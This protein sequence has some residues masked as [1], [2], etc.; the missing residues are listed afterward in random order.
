MAKPM[1]TKDKIREWISD[2]LR[3]MM[4]IGG[5][6][7]VVGL[8]ALAIHLITGRSDETKDSQTSFPVSQS[9]EQQKSSSSDLSSEENQDPDTDE[10]QQ[11]NTVSESTGEEAGTLIFGANNQQDVS[12]LMTGYFTALASGDVEELRRLSDQL[13]SEEEEQI[14]VKA[15]AVSYD[16]IETYTLEGPK[17]NTYIAFVKYECRYQGIET[18]LPMLNEVY[19]FQNADGNLIV[20]DDTDADAEAAAAMKAALE[21][22]EVQDL[23]EEVQALNDKALASD[24]DLKEYVER[25]S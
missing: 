17:E 13:S 20:M 6:L 3:Y 7:L 11:A 1:T 25:I 2:N 5:I 24:P 10:E 22:P 9:E 18:P 4:L 12:T 15:D 19:V 16:Q 14:A 21:Q 8:I 23:I